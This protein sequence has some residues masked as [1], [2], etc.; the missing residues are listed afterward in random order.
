MDQHPAVQLHIHPASDADRE[1]K[2]IARAYLDQFLSSLTSTTDL[3]AAVDKFQART[4]IADD[5]EVSWID[6]ADLRGWW[7]RPAK[8]EANRAILYLHGGGYACRTRLQ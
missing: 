3:R 5:I 4:P 7:L 1:D 6:D 2:K 8:A